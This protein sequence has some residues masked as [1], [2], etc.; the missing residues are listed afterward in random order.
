MKVDVLIKNG[1]VVDGSGSPGQHHLVAIQGDRIVLPEAEDNIEAA[2]VIDAQGKVIAPGFIDIHTHS[3]LT[4]LVDSRG[5]SKLSQGVTTEIT[6]NCG[7]SAAPCPPERRKMI[8]ESGTLL[9]VSGLDWSWAGFDDYVQLFAGNVASINLGYYMGH[10]AIRVS[11]M[12]YD[13]RKPTSTELEKMK[14]YVA[15]GMENG[16]VGL[17]SGLGYAPG[18]FSDLD[19]MVELC[20]VVAKYGGV[21]ATHM[22]D[23]G[24]GLLESVDEAIET[25]RRSGVSLQISHL[26]AVG[27]PNWPKLDIAIAK[28]E[29]ARGEGININ[30]DFYPYTASATS[31][32]SQLP[33]WAHEGGWKSLAK[34]IEDPQTR[35][36]MISEV[37]PKIEEAV[38]WHSIVVSSVRSDKNRHLE[39]KNIK[40]IG[41]M[42]NQKPVDAML[43]LL[44]EEDGGVNMVKFSMTEEG[45]KKV[46]AHPLS[47]IGSD[48]NAIATDGPLHKGKPHPRSYGTF[49]RV[50]RVYQR[51]HKLFSLEE[52]VHKMTVVPAC[53]LNIKDRGRVKEGY[54]ADLVIFDPETIAD[55]AT[56]TE[57]HQYSTGVDKVF[58]NGKLAYDQGKFLDPK[59]GVL[60]KP[61]K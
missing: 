31:L 23:E 25:A 20:K 19:E 1:L 14:E 32:S 38:G 39:G 55:V 15:Q 34:R 8:M 36:K 53:K 50:L 7:I 11:V 58:V 16:A 35:A 57:P 27:R 18:M 54:Y 6:G 13:N 2:Q 47:M 59:S 4:L 61:G 48:G 56:F 26:K 10:G 43:D 22:R 52:A 51:E 33:N 3:D 49:P 41:E 30:Y 45:V 37:D 46:A 21:Y 9:G 44:L 40:K 28:I 42:R 12:G 29:A 24:D 5:A 60:V 17:S